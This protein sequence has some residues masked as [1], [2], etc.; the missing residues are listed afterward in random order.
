MHPETKQ[1]IEI[2]GSVGGEV[3]RKATK[4]PESII[5]LK[6]SLIGDQNDPSTSQP[7][8][9]RVNNSGGTAAEGYS[10]T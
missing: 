4:S 10:I 6:A 8:Q 7:R 2:G 9:G 3:E 5:D 1:T